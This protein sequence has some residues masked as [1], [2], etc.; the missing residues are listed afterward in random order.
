LEESHFLRVHRQYIINL[1]HLK[2]L[3]RTKSLLTMANK[4]ELSIAR[5]QKDK[6]MEMYKWL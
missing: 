5:D 3:D 1:N 6:L 4:H 2:H